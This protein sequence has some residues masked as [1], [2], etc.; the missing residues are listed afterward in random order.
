MIT[1]YRPTIE[2]VSHPWRV[3]GPDTERVLDAESQPHHPL[4]H[5]QH[6]HGTGD[7]E[8]PDDS[9]RNQKPSP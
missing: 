6:A 8:R 3:A 4:M 9:K 7:G 5:H 2:E 1:T